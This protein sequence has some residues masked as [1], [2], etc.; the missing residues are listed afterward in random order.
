[1]SV[2]HF[3]V[4]GN[5]EKQE[6]GG[7]VEGDNWPSCSLQC[8]AQASKMPTDKIGWNHRFPRLRSGME[9]ESRKSFKE[10]AMIMGCSGIKNRINNFQ[11]CIWDT[12]K[13]NKCRN[14]GM[15]WLEELGTR[16]RTHLEPRMKWFQTALNTHKCMLFSPAPVNSR[17]HQYKRPCKG[18]NANWKFIFY[19]LTR[20]PKFFEGAH[21]RQAHISEPMATKCFLPFFFFLW[22]ILLEREGGKER[23]KR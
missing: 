13:K 3:A 15:E 22:E 12:F 11:Q 6:V 20:S 23:E 2:D 7:W 10:S 4:T 14:Q 18:E 16:L 19:K 8:E 9:G 21:V 5:T 1:M 17:Y